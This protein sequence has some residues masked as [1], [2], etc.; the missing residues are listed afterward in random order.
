MADGAGF[1]AYSFLEAAAAEARKA[2]R[3]HWAEG[4][5]ADRKYPRQPIPWWPEAP[6][7]GG[8]QA[9]SPQVGAQ[10]VDLAIG[11][12]G[13]DR[14]IIDHEIR[15]LIDA[16]LREVKAQAGESAPTGANAT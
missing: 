7:A 3:R 8:S 15:A 10:V 1:P 9:I 6:A 5:W 4:G 11:P 13:L 16:L 14:A 2:S 12:T